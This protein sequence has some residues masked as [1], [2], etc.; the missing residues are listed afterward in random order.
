MSI[1]LVNTIYPKVEKHSFKIIT[2]DNIESYIE[3]LNSYRDKIEKLSEEDKENLLR[4]IRY[5][6]RGKVDDDKIDRFI[7]FYIA[8]EIIGKNLAKN[9][10][11]WV[12]EICE[13]YGL[14][15]EYEGAKI[16]DIRDALVHA[17]HKKLSKEMAEELAI[18]YA[19]KFGEDVFKLII[20]FLNE[21]R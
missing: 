16:N 7:D 18:R 5:W 14:R 8:F 21:R 2:K 13:K 4:A 12:K 19:D 6:N 9:E 17:K 1:T 20:D 15:R 11:Q 3:E 10:K